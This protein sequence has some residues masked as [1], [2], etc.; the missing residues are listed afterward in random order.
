M[1]SYFKIVEIIAVVSS[2]L[3]TLLLQEGYEISWFFALFG[4]ALFLYLCFVRKIYAEALLQLFYIFTGVYGW[5]HFHET[6]GALS[7]SLNW[8][9]HLSIV[10]S[11]TGLLVISGAL[12]SRMTDAASPYMD[13]FT[14]VFSVFATLLM[15]NLIPEHWIYWIVIDA[16]SVVLYYRRKLYFTAGLFVLYTILSIRGAWEWLM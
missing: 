14:T 8:Q 11:A 12:L 1:R 6:A 7:P 4:S 5:M 16:V 13:S 2:L 3:F 9:T 10:L 15:I